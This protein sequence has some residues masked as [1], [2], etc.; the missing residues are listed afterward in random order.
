MMKLGNSGEYYQWFMETH[1]M[2]CLISM[3]IIGFGILLLIIAAMTQREEKIFFN[4]VSLGS[5]AL[6]AGLWSCVQTLVPQMTI[7]NM[8]LWQGIN[9]LTTFII[10]YP[11]MCFVSSLF[12]RPKRKY[13][14]IVL[15]MV[16]SAFITCF[17]LNTFHI[18]DY[19]ETLPIAHGAALVELVVGIIATVDNTKSIIGPVKKDPVLRISFCIF[20]GSVIV[21]MARY[22]FSDRGVDDSGHFMRLGLWLFIL[23]MFYRAMVNLVSYMQLA[24]QTEAIK[25][26]AY[27]DALTGIPNRAAFVRE[28]AKLQQAVDEGR[29]K[30][31][32]VCQMDINNLK[33]ANDRFG[34]AFGDEFIMRSS[35]AI[36]NAFRGFGSCY[37]VGGDEFTAFITEEPVNENYDKAV[38]LMKKTEAE[39]N[40]EQG[41]KFP[42]CIAYGA[43]V[44]YDKDESSA[45]ASASTKKESFRKSIEQAKRD[46]DQMMYIMKK[47]MKV[48]AGIADERMGSGI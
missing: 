22:M 47:E 33:S 40:A 12:E 34:H 18:L 14:T 25:K 30:N 10:P 6:L 11:A 20:L 17:V 3:N 37:R 15:Y 24:A 27:T 32:L 13:D 1:F 35:Y 8:V 23:I 2:S 16:F 36:D 46:A 9:Y 45:D 7:G 19:H 43:S 44:I 29:L 5:M 4:F 38:A 39:F 48:N 28:E 21:D 26:I 42:I 31:V 41:V